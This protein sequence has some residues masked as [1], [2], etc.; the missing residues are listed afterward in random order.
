MFMRK[1]AVNYLVFIIGLYFLAAGIVAI[2]R[3][4]PRTTPPSS[5]N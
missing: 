4:S 1:L 3:P 2:L 5:V